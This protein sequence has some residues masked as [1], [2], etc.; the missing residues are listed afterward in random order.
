MKI[1]KAIKQLG[2][3][4]NNGQFSIYSWIPYINALFPNSSYIF[5]DD[6][7]DYDFRYQC[8]PILNNAFM[9]KD[10]ISKNLSSFR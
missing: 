8:L 9:N 1:T 5:L 3:V 10:K 7:K 4:Y 6:I 2:N